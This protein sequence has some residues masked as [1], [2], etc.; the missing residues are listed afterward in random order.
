[1]VINVDGKEYEL[2]FGWDF[3]EEVNKRMGISVN[4]LEVE[5]GGYI[6]LNSA[7]LTKDPISLV[8]IIQSATNTE[9]QKPSK[10]GIQRFIEEKS[11][12]GTYSEFY[13]ELY[14]EIKKQ[15]LLKNLLG[16]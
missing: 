15:P 5:Q 13:D 7:V 11:I 4:G 9:R 12:D 10:I 2:I 14:D 3:L 16:E 8:D 1:M 6:K